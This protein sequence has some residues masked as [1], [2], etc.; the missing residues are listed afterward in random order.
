MDW[1]G[2]KSLLAKVAALAGLALAGMEAYE[3]LFGPI[4]GMDSIE[5]TP[6][7]AQ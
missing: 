2:T 1:N 6:S 5:T 7:E 3:E 4:E